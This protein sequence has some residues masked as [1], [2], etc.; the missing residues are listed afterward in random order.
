MRN[1][2][3]DLI[4]DLNKL[5]GGAALNQTFGTRIVCTSA[6]G[7]QQ[8]IWVIGA[9]DV[10][11]R[12]RIQGSTLKGLIVEELALLPEDFFNFAWSRLSV[13]G[14]KM[15]CSYNPE[16]PAHWAKKKV[17]DRC[18]EYGGE[19]VHFRM[20][21]NPSLGDDVIQRYERS[22]QGHFY[23]RM[24]EGQW[25][26]ASGACFPEWET[27]NKRFVDG[28]RWHLA[29][30]WAVS[31]TLAALA[32][33]SKGMQGIVSHEHY[34]RG[35]EHVSLTEDQ[36]V[37]KICDWWL[38]A[39]GTPTRGVLLWPDPATPVT[40]KRKMRAKGFQLRTSDNDVVPGIMTTAA[41]LA[42]QEVLIHED[43]VELTDEM[44]G[45]TWDQTAA[46]RGEDKPNKENDHGC[47]ALRYWA[48]STGKAYRM[49]KP[50]SVREA[51]KQ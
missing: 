45:Y 34:Y 33:H 1:I 13:A 11:A 37:E 18:Q 32:I 6:A 7:K 38:R 51:L 27:T 30:D 8:N 35:R 12:K 10:Q 14:A 41:R 23:K 25:S 44:S 50:M 17:V 22:F 49:M 16:G 26:A 42:N 15:W 4:E 21:D 39:T 40:F 47:D 46:D 28:G 2:G 9:N 48:H 5:G 19:V 43:C 20:R 24:I 29:M 3:F 31:G 36:A